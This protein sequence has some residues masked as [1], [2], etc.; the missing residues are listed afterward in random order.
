MA[1]WHIGLVGCGAWGRL[2]LR[3]L[4]A[5][6]ARV[7]VVAQS[8][9]GRRAAHEGGADAV[10]GTLEEL[11]PVQGV[12][13]ATPTAT[14][15]SIIDSVLDR[16]VPIFCEKPL[17]PDPQVAA[18]LA[19]AAPDRLFVMD[20]WRYHPGIEAL[21]DLLG[22]GGLGEPVGI[23]TVRVG[24]GN[25]HRDVDPV[26]I[27][28]PHDLSI[29]FEILGVLPAARAAVA[30]VV[31][32]AVWGLIGHLGPAPWATVQ[33]SASSHRTH[34]D[35]RVVGQDGVAWLSGSYADAIGIARPPFTAEPRWQPVSQE[36]PLLRELRTFLEHLEGGPP[37]RSGA[38]EAAQIVTRVDELRQL[39]G[40]VPAGRH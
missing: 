30:E 8:P 13:V 25:R 35:V 24:W 20:K 11:A 31:D 29:V 26:W 33:V 1:R 10:I 39:A 23:H 18:R 15:A 21:R 2:I 14:H 32:D 38:A 3:D 12:I 36:M 28:A 37:P 7:D 9:A 17:A 6:G 34:R 16:A 22:S 40:L 4:K 5:L 27:L 19:G